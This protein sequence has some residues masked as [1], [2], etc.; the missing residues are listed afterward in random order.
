[1]KR[2]GERKGEERGGGGG[3]RGVMLADWMQPRGACAGNIMV[4]CLG[5]GV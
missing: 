2:M 3:R 1:M 5:Y 4:W